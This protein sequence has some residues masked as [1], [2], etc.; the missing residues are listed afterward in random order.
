MTSKKSFKIKE[1][2]NIKATAADNKKYKIEIKET[3]TEEKEKWTDGEE[4]TIDDKASIIELDSAD[5][6]TGTK[7]EKAK[8]TL[9]Y[10]EGLFTSYFKIKEVDGK[11]F[12]EKE[13]KEVSTKGMNSFRYP[14]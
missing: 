14:F 6:E 3:P 5:K 4:I 10:K 2:K 11:E 13:Q 9:I 7:N 12:K 1:K 8:V